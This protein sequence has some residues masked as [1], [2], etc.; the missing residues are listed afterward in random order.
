METHLIQVLVRRFLAIL[1]L[2]K[3][4]VLQAITCNDTDQAN[5]NPDHRLHI[6][7]LLVLNPM[8]LLRKLIF[9][10][11]KPQF[12]LSRYTYRS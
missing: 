8:H 9:H 4:G 3:E 5:S 1:W 11:Y 2:Q 6:S 10:F 7:Y 12:S